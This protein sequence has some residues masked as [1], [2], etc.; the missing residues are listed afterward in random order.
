VNV[1][2]Y[3][4]RTNKE[5][6]SRLRAELGDDAVVLKNQSV[7]GGVEILAMADDAA[8]TAASDAA[9]AHGQD[10]VREPMREMVREPNRE[11]ARDD[12]G[13]A[14][15]RAPAR[16]P[17]HEPVREMPDRQGAAEGGTET[18]EMSTLSFQQYVRDRLAQRLAA[19][20]TMGDVLGEQRSVHRARIRIRRAGGAAL[21]W[22]FSRCDGIDADCRDVDA[23][24]C[25]GQPDRGAAR[26]VDAGDP[27]YCAVRRSGARAPE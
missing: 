21:R 3:F 10:R 2:R 25:A 26:D 27:E 14:H 17:L 12:V 20:P 1:K 6:M 22:P 4:G 16:E 9:R 5:A 7:P 13:R 15:D 24:E 18:P 11:Q 23:D 8:V 19:A